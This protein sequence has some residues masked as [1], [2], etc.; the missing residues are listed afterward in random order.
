VPKVVKGA[1][2]KN[3][4]S[5]LISL[6]LVA[7]VGLLIRWVK[8]M[9]PFTTDS[10]N[11]NPRPATSYEEA[12]ARL[13]TLQA[14]DGE[15]VNPLCFTTLHTHGHPTENVLVYL[16]GFTN[17]PPQFPQLAPVFFEKGYNVL[18]PRI[19]LHGMQDRTPTQ[20][21]RLTAEDLAQFTDEVLD[22][23]QGLGQKVTLLG[24]SLGGTMTGWAAHYRNDID[25]AVLGGPLLAIKVIPRPLEK[26]VATVAL[27]LPDIFM[28][29]DPR[30][31]LNMP[32]WHA[33]P[34]YTTHAMAQSMRL[35]YRVKE[36]AVTRKPRAR[37]ALVISNAA[38]LA[39]ANDVIHDMI[40]NWRKNGAENV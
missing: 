32:P 13:Q 3:I 5:L 27:N 29:W 8:N 26:A 24:L 14:R 20:F 25:L 18:I 31:R 15:E 9:K 12:L 10:L 17:C 28:W 11:P 19:P 23:A 36:D 34:G 35:A 16:H 6:G 21:G 1:S 40:N 2:I 30:V 39:V 4:R 22:I 7:G 33:Y 38:D 37:K